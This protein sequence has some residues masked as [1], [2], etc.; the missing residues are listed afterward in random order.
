MSLIDNATLL[1]GSGNYYTAAVGTAIPSDLSDPASYTGWENVG[2]TDLDEVLSIA[3]EG[4]EQTTIG[5]LQNSALRVRIAPRSET[6]SIPLQQFDV[7]A[8]KLFYGSN[9]V[10]VENGRLL[11]VPQNPAPT[12]RA[13]LAVFLD[14]ETAFGVYAPKASIFRGGDLEIAD[15]ESLATLPLAVTPLVHGT[16]RWAYAVTPLTDV[17]EVD[18]ETP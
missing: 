7:G 12:E 8:L 1:V 10:E 18:P 9:A 15:T 13:F 5:T 17:T 4:G 3:S 14:G 11:G 6:I 16:N 2:H